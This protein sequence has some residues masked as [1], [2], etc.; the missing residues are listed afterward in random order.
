MASLASQTPRRM[1]SNRIQHWLNIPWRAGDHPE[2]FTRGR[3]LLASASL[4]S[5]NRRTFS[6]AITAWSANV[7][8]SLICAGVKGR[9]SM[10]R[11]AVSQ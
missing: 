10:R 11:R 9:T 4:S 8:S 3:L 5:W 7:S 6:M 1:F 2:N